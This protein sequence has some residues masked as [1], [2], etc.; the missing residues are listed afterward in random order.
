MHIEFQGIQLSSKQILH[1]PRLLPQLGYDTL[2]SRVECSYRYELSTKTLILERLHVNVV[3][4]GS[5]TI[6]ARVGNLDLAALLSGRV[7]D[8]TVAG[9]LGGMLIE[10]GRLHY[11][12]ASLVERMLSSVA[13]SRGVSLHTYRQ[14]LVRKISI[15]L[16]KDPGSG[17]GRI[18]AALLAFLTRSTQ[19]FA[20]VAPDRPIALFWL[21]WF[22]DI[23]K[24]VDQLGL[25]VSTIPPHDRR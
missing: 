19:L 20:T 4:A 6:S 22:R 18:G 3:D 13:R 5:A 23:E 2:R 25:Q 11:V 9:R 15:F 8:A 1:N 17:A 14:Q 10:Q 24:L 7:G 16:T 12:D 21:L